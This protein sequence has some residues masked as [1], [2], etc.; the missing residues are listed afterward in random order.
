MILWD[1]RSGSDSLYGM[2][3]IALS[4]LCIS[5]KNTSTHRKQPQRMRLIPVSLSSTLEM[6]QFLN[7]IK[8]FG[9]CISMKGWSQAETLNMTACSFQLKYPSV[10]LVSFKTIFPFL[11]LP[12]PISHHHEMRR[13]R[14]IMC[15]WTICVFFFQEPL[16]HWLVCSPKLIHN[17]YTK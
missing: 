13:W 2:C 1:L 6:L 12:L 3:L 5:S 9:M 11:N 16:Q 14:Y 8:I 4:C 15:Q 7:Y 10:H 17:V